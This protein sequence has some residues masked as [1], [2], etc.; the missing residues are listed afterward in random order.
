MNTCAS[1]LRRRRINQSRR[2]NAREVSTRTRW[3]PLLMAR[4]RWRSIR[5]TQNSSL[6]QYLDPTKR[7]RRNTTSR[8]ARRKRCIFGLKQSM[9]SLK[10]SR[11]TLSTRPRRALG[12]RA[13]S[14]A[15]LRPALRYLP[16][17]RAHFNLNRTRTFSRLSSR[18]CS[19][20]TAT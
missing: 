4:A 15:H 2:A 13:G 16:S 18:S 7:R 1:R 8:R 3:P 19:S 17:G 5:L 20:M 10:I 12:A 11:M 6:S 9:L 14:L